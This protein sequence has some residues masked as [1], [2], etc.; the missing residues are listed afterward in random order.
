MVLTQPEFT[1]HIVIFTEQ[2]LT[3]YA[4]IHSVSFST[5]TTIMNLA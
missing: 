5:G 1:F 3:I 4:S 2:N